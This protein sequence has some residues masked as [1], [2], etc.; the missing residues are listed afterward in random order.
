MGLG[1]VGMGYEFTNYSQIKLD[2]FT[3]LTAARVQKNARVKFARDLRQNAQKGDV[4]SPC[5]L[6]TFSF[7]L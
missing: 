2:L 1:L 6:F 3:N 7:L 4:Q 5:V